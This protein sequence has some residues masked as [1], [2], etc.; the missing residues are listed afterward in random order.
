MID[1]FKPIY[2]LAIQEQIDEPFSFISY[3]TSHVGRVLGDE[4][5]YDEITVPYFKLAEL[6]RGSVDHETFWKSKYYKERLL[7]KA[8]HAARNSLEIDQINFED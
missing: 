1:A 2:V 4:L 8:Y 3:M 6:L 7:P 5:S